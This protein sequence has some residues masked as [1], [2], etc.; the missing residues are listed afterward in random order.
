MAVRRVG[1]RV[2]GT[3][4]AT[5]TVGGIVMLLPR[6]PTFE[7]ASAAPLP[8]AT[9]VS[10]QPTSTSP[11]PPPA[12]RP[13]RPYPVDAIFASYYASHDGP[14]VLGQAISPLTSS[15]G[16]AAQYFEKARLE[17]RRATNRSGDPAYDFEY[18]LLVDEMKAVRSLRPVGG[19]RSDVTYDTIQTLSDP[20]R[21][22]APPPDFTGNV[23]ER[24]DGSAFVPFSTDLS[25]APG[26]IVPTYFWE[27]MNRDDLFPAGWLH[28]VGLPITPTIEARVDKGVIVGSEI[29]RVTNRPIVV[30]AF[31]RT[32]LTYDPANPAGFLVERA[33]TGTDFMAVFPDRVP[34]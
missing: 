20:S 22:V 27:F 4:V 25:A 11:Q 16:V 19:D 8:Q 18:G 14:R 33:N 21:R 30:Q 9:A 34:Q 1:R 7:D 10:P 29:T 3:V 17:D 23:Q 26:H 24:A 13:V 15:G 5:A 12:S 31:Q 28:D 6:T 2:V 32:I